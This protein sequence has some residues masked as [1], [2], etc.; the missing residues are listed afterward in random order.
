L[1]IDLTKINGEINLKTRVNKAKGH[2]NS[3][4][5]E[6]KYTAQSAMIKAT[7]RSKMTPANNISLDL[8]SVAL[9]RTSKKRG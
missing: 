7:P 6:A 1:F 4:E 3:G 5:V 8:C 9:S 2:N